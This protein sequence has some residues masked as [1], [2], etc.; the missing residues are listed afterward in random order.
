MTGIPD[1]L[2]RPVSRRRLLGSAA[3]AATAV[4]SAGLL[5]ACTGDGAPEKAGS[6]GTGDVAVSW[7][8]WSNGPAEGQQHQKFSDDYTKMTG[9][10]VTYQVVAGDYLAKMLDQFAAGSAPDAF[11][12]ADTSL[13]QLVGNQ[14]LQALDDYLARSD[15]ALKF[16][17]TFPGLSQWCKGLDGKVYGIP[18]DCSPKVMWFNKVVLDAADVSIDPA[19]SFDAGNWTQDACGE[20]F[21]QVRASGK[22]A[23][24]LENNW[25]DTLSWFTTFGGTV[26]DDNGKSIVDT[27]EKSRS[28]GAWL[29]EQLKS[30]N[31]VYGSTLPNGQA[32]NTLFYAGQLATLGYGRWELPNLAKL[33]KSRMRYDIAPFPSEDGKTVAPVGV[34]TAAM[35]VNGNANNKDGALEFL[36][37]YCGADGMRARLTAG[38]GPG[39]AVP[40]RSGLDDTVTADDDPLHAEFFL[41]AAKNGYAMP[42]VLARDPDKYAGFAKML[43]SMLAPEPL[44]TL[45]TD[46]F[47]T[48]YASFLNA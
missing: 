29:L 16:D 22:R 48:T 19:E 41:R 38:D 20:L 4:G 18:V 26:F 42:L 13:A 45:T 33:P 9:T 24:V 28:A 14:S 39:N 46:T 31:I 40:S 11:Y 17:E 5:V 15:V 23:A 1:A 36:A 6:S 7:Q 27:D 44:R 12:V 8:S 37:Y 32:A 47:L 2:R 10:K 21:S 3:L 43:D 34:Y 35:S 25:F 30:G